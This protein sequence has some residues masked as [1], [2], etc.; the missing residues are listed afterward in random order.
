LL[1][2]WARIRIATDWKVQ[3]L[4]LALVG[5]WQGFFALSVWLLG[6][7]WVGVCLAWDFAGFL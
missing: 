1:V 4:L 6:F 5:V 3:W 7:A 2:G